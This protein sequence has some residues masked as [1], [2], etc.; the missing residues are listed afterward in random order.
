MKSP[1]Y[2]IEQLQS[3][4]GLQAIGDLHHEI[5][6]VNDL[7]LALPHEA[8]FLENNLYSSRLAASQA[9]LIIVSS[10]VK[11]EEGK[12]YF[13]SLAP[14]L[15]FQKLIELYISSPPSAYDGEIHPTALIHP[16]LVKGNA[17]TIGP[18]S[19]I[20]LGVVIKDGTTIGANCFIGAEVQIG[21]NCEIHPN[22]VIREGSIIGDRCIIQSG[23]VIGSSGYGYHTDKNGKHHLLKQL[24]NVIIEDDVDIGANT[25]IDRARFKSTIIGKGTKIDN[26][27]QIAHQVEIG[28]DCLIVSQVGIAGSTKIGNHVVIGGQSGISGHL[29]ITDHVLL[30][31]RSGLTKSIREKGIY[32]GAP[33]LLEKEFKVYYSQLKGIGKLNKRVAALEERLE[34]AAC[35]ELERKELLE[36]V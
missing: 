27:V 7:Q 2:T 12:N 13:I 9:G 33:A 18:R 15:T 17:I 1:C 34:V 19:V 29:Q 16:S 5:T 6:G 24:G 25:T 21:A 32:L 8:S 31:A 11:L 4:L 20:D 23:A 10:N 28:E 3:I 26:L 14:S 22:V 36:E 35:N 30:G